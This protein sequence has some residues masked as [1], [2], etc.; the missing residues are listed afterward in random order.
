[1]LFSSG[2]VLDQGNIG[3]VDRVVGGVADDD[4]LEL[5]EVEGLAE[6][7]H[8]ELAVAGLDG[9][10]RLLHV[11]AGDGPEHVGDGHVLL[12]HP[13]AVDPDAD[14]AIQVPAQGDLADA[15]HRLQLLLH[16]VAGHVGQDVP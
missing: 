4:L 14:V 16:L 12:G 13:A 15:G 2:T 6:H 1:M 9:A 5:L 10:T 11:V 8:A 3:E 7:A